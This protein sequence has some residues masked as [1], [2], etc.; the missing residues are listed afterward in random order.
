MA[1]FDRLIFGLLWVSP[2]VMI[3][4]VV[5]RSEM[6]VHAVYIICGVLKQYERTFSSVAVGIRSWGV[7]LNI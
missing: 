5:L 2:D 7:G 4:C 1:Y 6:K 3:G